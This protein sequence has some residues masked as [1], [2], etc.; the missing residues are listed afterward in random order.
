MKTFGGRVANTGYVRRREQ[1]NCPGLE[2]LEQGSGDATD[3][4]VPGVAPDEVRRGLRAELS[5]RF[6]PG[7]G[8]GDF[9][10]F[11]ADVPA[12][13]GSVRDCAFDSIERNG[14]PRSSGCQRKLSFSL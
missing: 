11:A 1:M 7:G 8:G 12:L 3:G 13:A 5:W 9:G 2:P 14:R 6:E 10:C 4:A